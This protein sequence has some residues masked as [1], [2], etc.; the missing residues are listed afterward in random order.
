VAKQTDDL[1]MEGR[2]GQPAGTAPGNFLFARALSQP[3]GASGAETPEPIEPGRTDVGTLI[4]GPEISFIGEITACNRLVVDGMVEA[5]LPRCQEVVVG[6]RGFFKG[7]ARTETAE[8]HGRIEGEL[9]VRKL[10][11]IHA[12]GQVSGSTTYGEIEIERGGRIIGQTQAREGS[13]RPRE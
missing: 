8:V 6:E 1:R 2:Q 10:L 9:V 4:I 5:T 7:E 11:R 13:Q 3:A 12:A